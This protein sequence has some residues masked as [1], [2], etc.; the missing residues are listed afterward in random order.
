M[1]MPGSQLPVVATAVSASCRS[2]KLT[3]CVCVCVR[4]CVGVWVP[5][6]LLQLVGDGSELPLPLNLR[7]A[8]PHGLALFLA[9]VWHEANRAEAEHQAHTFTAAGERWAG[10][11]GR[12]SGAGT[13][14]WGGSWQAES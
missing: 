4:G 12:R 13:S 8:S 6:P 3:S 7:R 1:A 2:R 9:C 10:K 14:C 11:R 5:P